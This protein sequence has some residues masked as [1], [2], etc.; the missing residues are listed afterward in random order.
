[1]ENTGI[2]EQ[3]VDLCAAGISRS[4]YLLL[5]CDLVGRRL[6]QAQAGLQPWLHSILCV[7]A[8]FELIVLNH[9]YGASR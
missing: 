5:R 7:V 3:G 4:V 1:M 6:I 8:V 2:L 9:F